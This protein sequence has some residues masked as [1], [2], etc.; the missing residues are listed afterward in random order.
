[1]TLVGAPPHVEAIRARGLEI[2]GIR[3]ERVVR[4]H[5]EAVATPAEAR[6][7][8]DYLILAVKAK[9]TESALAEADA[10]A[11]AHARGALA[12]EHAREGGEPRRLARRASA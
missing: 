1:M 12:P 10:A 11:R 2:R 5:L 8:F 3:G 6:G 9:D 7:D 4:R